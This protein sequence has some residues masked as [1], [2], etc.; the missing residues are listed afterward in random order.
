MILKMN[1]KKIVLYDSRKHF[2]RFLKWELK[3]TFEFDYFKDFKCFKDAIND[4][5]TILFV[6]Y[7]KE[8]IINLMSIYKKGIAIIVCTSSNDFLF[9]M[10]NIDEILL[11]NTSEIKSEV[12]AKM[13]LNINLIEKSLV[14]LT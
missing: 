8:E 6:V 12:I 4:Y 14:E 9:K 11:L 7:S 5:Y 3:N 13:R 2:Y 10:K 1:T